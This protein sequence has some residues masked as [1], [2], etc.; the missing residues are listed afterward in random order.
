MKQPFVFKG[1]YRER[2]VVRFSDMSGGMGY[3]KK[4]YQE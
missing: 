1:L 4:G 2:C 3:D